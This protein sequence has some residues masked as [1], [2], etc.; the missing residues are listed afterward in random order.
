MSEPAARPPFEGVS[1]DAGGGFKLWFYAAVLRLLAGAIERFD[2]WNK[3]FERFPFLMHYSNEVTRAGFS[4][5]D[6]RDAA[7]A[8]SAAVTAWEK[9]VDSHLPLRALRHATGLD[10]DAIALFCALGLVEEDPRFG[11]VFDALQGN[12]GLRRP[13]IGLLGTWWS[14]AGDPGVR[15]IARRLQELGLAQPVSIDGPRSEWSFAVPP[16]IWDAARGEQHAELAAGLRF[17]PREQ[18][19]DLP[20]YIAGPSLERALAP[21]PALI[22]ADGCGAVVLRGPRHNG[23]RTAAGALARALGRGLIDADPPGPGGEDRWRLLGPLATLLRAVPFTRIDLGPG[24]V[25]RI[26][27]PHGCDAPMIVASGRH[28]GL[29]GSALERAVTI[30]MDRPR[31]ADRLR[32]WTAVLAEDEADD[33]PTIVERFRLTSGHIARAARL[34]RAHARADSRRAIRPDDVREAARAM[35]R[36]TL[37]TLATWLPPA[38]DWRHVSVPPHVK[39]DL[40]D[41]E[42][43]C[44]QRERLRDAVGPALGPQLTCKTVAMLSGP[45]GVGKS[46]AARAL[47]AAL[48]M[49][50]YRVDVA[51]ILDKFVGEAEKRLVQLFA[52]AEELDVVLALDE[53]DSL[54][55][56]RT[57]G[58][59]ATDRYANAETST[60]LTALDSFDGILVVTTN[61]ADKID[62]AF[63]R[64]MDVVIEF[65]AP[66][67]SER[68]AI[69]RMH[70]P[71]AHAV[72]ERALADVAASCAL[73]G[74]QIR[75]AVLHACSLALD[76]NR[77]PDAADVRAGVEREYR[78]SGGICP[79]SGAGVFAHA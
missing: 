60:L 56:R 21:L 54:M 39:R 25:A 79:L 43:R 64:R 26:D 28:G 50:A 44:R 8:W 29:S 5:L 36:E 32:Q 1:R 62:S 48:H 55:S 49:D 34:A 10:A 38:V 3:L 6:A 45:S 76:A 52:R 66:D 73:T 13:S 4:G 75:N 30:A 47:A 78:K 24:E 63:L 16:A 22:A 68:F 15:W 72:D 31:P 74:G 67:P 37:E 9:T 35:S 27:R 59:S 61:A 69:W 77:P 40:D 46:I 41:L 71:E 17:T 18:L 23:R 70:L 14:E 20:A 53:G 2:D 11:A 7:I 65:P 42:R 51:A 12:A 58:S 57:S 33:L 19:L